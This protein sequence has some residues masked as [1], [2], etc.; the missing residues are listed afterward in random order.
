MFRQ[1][2]ETRASLDMSAREYLEWMAQ[3]PPGDAV[4]DLL[5]DFSLEKARPGTEAAREPG[6]PAQPPPCALPPG[7]L[8]RAAR[9]RRAGVA[10]SGLS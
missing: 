5:V 9:W 7:A 1:R 6:A 3:H 4:P 8:T 2:N 10:A